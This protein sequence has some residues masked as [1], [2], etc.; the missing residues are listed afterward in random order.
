M[1]VMWMKRGRHMRIPAFG[2]WEK[3]NEM[4][5]TQ[6]FESARQ[7]GLLRYS[8]SS[9]E[10]EV[11]SVIAARHFDAVD[12]KK[13]RTSS[14]PPPDPMRISRRGKRYCQHQHEHLTEATGE[15]HGGAGGG[16]GGRKVFDVTVTVRQRQQQQQ[17]QQFA[18]K[19][20]PAVDAGVAVL[21]T[22]QRQKKNDGVCGLGGAGSQARI[23]R[24]APKAVDE[25]LYK[26][27]PHLLPSSHRK[28]KKKL[29]FLTRCLML[30]CAL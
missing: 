6:Y 15:R 16:G 11:P 21:S 13:P 25:D 26:V 30:P 18:K 3:V 27:P 20:H 5:I 2:D 1:D 28:K 19:R 4:P 12:A 9:G 10:C 8:S 14:L 17:Q 23:P 7:A 22:K 24:R 29:G